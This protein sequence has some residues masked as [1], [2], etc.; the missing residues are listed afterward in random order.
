[1]ELLSR[2]TAVCASR[3]AFMVAPVCT[4]TSVAVRRVPS[5]CEVVPRVA[6]SAVC[7]N[8]LF[9]AAPLLRKMLAPEAKFRRLSI[10]NIHTALESPPPSRVIELVIVTALAH[11]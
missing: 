10:W 2:V 6:P 4:A 1:M 8:M 9:A 11:L 7:Q 5:K 3:R